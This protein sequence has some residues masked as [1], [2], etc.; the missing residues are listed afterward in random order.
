MAE[1]A[2]PNVLI[3]KAQTIERATKRARA[4]L[5]ASASFYDDVD[6]QDVAVLNVIRACEA[7]IDI[8]HHLIRALSLGFAANSTEAFA[9]LAKAEII[10]GTTSLNLSR[11]AGFRNI[12]VH[13][14]VSL[15]YTLVVQIIVHGLDDIFAF[16]A[17]MVR[18]F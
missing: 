2:S 8:G 18:R 15:D 17:A 10:D 1:M 16:S 6:A 9:L 3:A 14:Y 4:A 5:A 12:A 7:T 13:D 11:M